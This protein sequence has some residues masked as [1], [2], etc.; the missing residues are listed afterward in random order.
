MAI[1]IVQCIVVVVVVVVC[2]L[3]QQWTNYTCRLII[4]LRSWS[5]NHL[6]YLYNEFGYPLFFCISD[7]CV[8]VL[9]VSSMSKG[10]LCSTFH[11]HSLLFWKPN[12]PVKDEIERRIRGIFC[13]YYLQSLTMVFNTILLAN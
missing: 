11:L 12:F 6:Y 4:N 2:K 1:K 5:F 3:V 9:K 7:F 13:N 8:N 10:Y